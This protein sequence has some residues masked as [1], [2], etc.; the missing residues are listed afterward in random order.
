M[1]KLAEFRR[2]VYR[3]RWIRGGKRIG[4][5][6]S[7]LKGGPEPSIGQGERAKE[8]IDAAE[9]SSE[10]TSV[11]EKLG[12]LKVDVP[13]IPDTAKATQAFPEGAA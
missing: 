11:K 5:N 12:D 1:N 9:I 8:G 3:E 4:E 10:R 7:Y 6:E 13:T 2:N